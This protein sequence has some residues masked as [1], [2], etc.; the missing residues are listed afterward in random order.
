MNGCSF[1]RLVRF[2]DKKLDLDNR[3]EILNHLDSC[4]ICRDTIY[5]IARDRD[6]SLLIYKPYRQH[7]NVA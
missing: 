4:D 3:L 7:G 5:Q 1:K 2:L 6:H